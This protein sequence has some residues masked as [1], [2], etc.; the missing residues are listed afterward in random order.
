MRGFDHDNITLDFAHRS[1]HFGN[2]A[3]LVR[4]RGKGVPRRGDGM[5]AAIPAAREERV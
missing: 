3:S 4:R 2:L 1:F 5:L